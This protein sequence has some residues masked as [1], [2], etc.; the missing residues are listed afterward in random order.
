MRMDT[1]L[2]GQVLPIWQKPALSKTVPFKITS[3][4]KLLIDFRNYCR[5]SKR[6]SLVFLFGSQKM[7]PLEESTFTA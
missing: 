3:K 7:T 5:P 1:F 2:E 6:Y 4:Q